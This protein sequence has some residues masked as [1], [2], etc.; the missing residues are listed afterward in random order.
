VPDPKTFTQEEVDAAVEKK[1]VE[2]KAEGDK[3][4]QTLW[5]EAKSAKARAKEF[6]GI[7]AQ[8]AREYKKKITELEHQAKANKAG[9]TSEQLEKMRGEIRGDLEKEYSPSKALAEKL[10]AENRALKLDTVVK[11]LMG[12]NG[13]RAERVESLFKLTADQFDL[14]EDGQP[15]LKGRMGTPVDK[16]IAENLSK[17]YPEFYVGTGSS[18]GGASRSNGV[19]D[20]RPRTVAGDSKSIISNLDDIISGK[21]TVAE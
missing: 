5:E 19:G 8:E 17:E 13:V 21:V 1:L 9:I 14:T 3:S 2:A 12:K 6:D 4:F 15:M 7:D 16:H 10:S 18:G 11:G 20:T